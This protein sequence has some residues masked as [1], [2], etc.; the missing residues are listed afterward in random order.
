MGMLGERG[1]AATG[2]G[3]SGGFGIDDIGD[4]LN[5]EKEDART[6]NPDIGDILDGFKK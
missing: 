5:R 3:G 4:L 2:S 1:G 6:R